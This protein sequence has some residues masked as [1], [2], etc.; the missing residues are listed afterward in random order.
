MLLAVSL[1]SLHVGKL[2]HCSPFS[3][4]ILPLCPSGKGPEDQE[5]RLNYGK[6]GWRNI[7]Q[8][9]KK[10]QEKEEEIQLVKTFVW[11]QYYCGRVNTTW[12]HSVEWSPQLWHRPALSLSRDL[13]FFLKCE[14]YG[15]SLGRQWKYTKM[16]KKTFQGKL[17]ERQGD[18]YTT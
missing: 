12:G 8:G 6:V 3:L 16:W 14:N 2:C 11:G 7:Y 4:L 1:S 13:P 9:R 10:E 17:K 18:V 5:S 15:E